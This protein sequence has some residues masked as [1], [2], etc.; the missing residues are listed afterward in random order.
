MDIKEFTGAIASALRIDAQEFADQL[1]TD[2]GELKPAEAA[3]KVAEV[4]RSKFTAAKKEQHARATRE[5]WGKVERLVK[6]AGFDSE[7]LQGDALL[8]AFIENK[9]ATPPAKGEA[10]TKEQLAKMPEV[11]E[12]VKEGKQAAAK[13]LADTLNE[14]TTYKK[15]VEAKMAQETGKRIALSELRKANVVLGDGKDPDMEERRLNA[16]L[17]SVGGNIREKDGSIVFVNADGGIEEDDYGK[18]VDY[19][20]KVVETGKLLFGTQ[21]VTPGRNG[22]S[23]AGSSNATPG[24]AGIKMSFA[25][26]EDFN[27]FY[28]SETDPVKRYEGLQAYQQQQEKA[29]G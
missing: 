25:S 7:D 2:G 26:Q 23:P 21:V 19:A 3:A 28:A 16:I 4:I 24:A 14:F 27:K 5:V 10:L 22:A 9:S 18:P 8:T 13:Q 11:A 6:T 1:E 17:L 12:L 15:G 29:A 20:K